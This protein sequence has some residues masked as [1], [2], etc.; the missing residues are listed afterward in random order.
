MGRGMAIPARLSFVTLGVRDVT[1]AAAF[2]DALGWERAP[3]PSDAIVFYRT[4]GGLLALFKRRALAKD[5][6]LPDTGPGGFGGV[7]I[8]I[9]VD[10]REDV[11]AGLAAAVAAGAT[12]LRAAEDMPW[13]G[14]SGYFA[15]PDGHAWEIAWNPAFP[16]GPDGR[17]Q[18][19]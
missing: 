11:D 7:T 10:R 13:G 18:L 8:A 4:A 15:D 14:R 16:I 5:A 3:F 19:P 2:Y 12:A 17:P 9:N 6:G 1:R